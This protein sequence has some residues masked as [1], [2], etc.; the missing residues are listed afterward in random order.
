[1]E[2]CHVK[3]CTDVPAELK[4]SL[5]DLY[6]SMDENEKVRRYYKNFKYK[7]KLLK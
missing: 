5:F 3:T 6:Y 2:G 1:M 7:K 4:K